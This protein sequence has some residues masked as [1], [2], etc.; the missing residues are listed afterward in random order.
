MI[1]YDRKGMLMPVTENSGDAEQREQPKEEALHSEHYTYSV[2]TVGTELAVLSPDSPVRKRI[3]SYGKYFKTMHIVLMSGITG[4]GSVHEDNVTVYPTNSP[5]KVQR[6]LDALQIGKAIT[7]V[8][9]VSSQDPFETGFIAWLIARHHKAPLHVQLHTDF[10]APEY[11]SHSIINR[12]RVLIAGFIIHRASRVRVVSKEV[13]ESITARYGTKI[14]V[15]VIP[16]YTDLE[17]FRNATMPAHMSQKFLTFPRRALVVSRFEPE[18]DISLAIRAFAE[19][20]PKDACLILLGEGSEYTILERLVTKLLL[21]SRVFFEGFKDP[22]PYYALCDILLVPSIYE[23][24]GQVIVEAL[25]AHK[26]VLSTDVGIAR[27]SG[28][29]IAAPEQFASAL[30]EWF[31]NGPK[32]MELKNYPYA[33]QDDYVQ[34]YCADIASVKKDATPAN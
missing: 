2:L 9:I 32:T 20:A 33:S 16:I 28:A 8:D 34:K 27:T 25:A 17:R 13:G 7:G 1:Q 19:A 31:E 24:Y 21:D 18:K 14:P 10:L 22:A 4:Q 3:F 26:P 30:K 6:F 11:A 12:I 5:N 23:G 29:I 15:S